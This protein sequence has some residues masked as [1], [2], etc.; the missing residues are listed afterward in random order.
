MCLTWCHQKQL[1][2]WSHEDCW[3]QLC[4]LA[5]QT[6]PSC[7]SC[8]WVAADLC[9]LTRAPLPGTGCCHWNVNLTQTAQKLTTEALAMLGLGYQEDVVDVLEAFDLPFRQDEA[10]QIWLNPDDLNLPQ[11]YG[12][13]SDA[14]W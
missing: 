3:P 5:G 9:G 12:Q 14:C 7:Q 11:I 1:L 8:R 13:G 6:H 10:E 2:Y 4:T